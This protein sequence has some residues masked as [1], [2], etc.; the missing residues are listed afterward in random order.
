MPGGE[1]AVLH[2]GRGRGVGPLACIEARGVELLAIQVRLRPCAG[3]G[4][5]PEVDEHAEA[6]V[7]ELP[8]QLF[9]RLAWGDTCVGRRGTLTATG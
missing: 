2:L 7:D 4:E 6:Q 9:Q 5:E 8:L 3:V 1:H